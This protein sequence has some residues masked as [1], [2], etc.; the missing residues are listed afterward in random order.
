M[1]WALIAVSAASNRSK[2]DQDPAEWLPPA[3]GELCSYVADW[4]AVKVRWRLSVDPAERTALSSLI[5]QCP[6]ARMPVVTAP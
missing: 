5:G 3:P 6:G 4:I 1:P 2:G